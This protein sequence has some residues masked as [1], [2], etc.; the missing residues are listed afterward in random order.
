MFLLRP[1]PRSQLHVMR[2]TERSCHGSESDGATTG[3]S[4]TA[5]SATA[6]T[7]IASVTAR[8]VTT[9]GVPSSTPLVTPSAAGSSTRNGVS[10]AAPP[11]PPPVVVATQNESALLSTTTGA[12]S[13]K[14]FPVANATITTTIISAAAG[15]GGRVHA[16]DGSEHP[17]AP[18]TTPTPSG[19]CDV[20]NKKITNNNASGNNLK[21]VARVTPDHSTAQVG[22]TDRVGSDSAGSE[23]GPAALSVERFL[24]I[25]N[26]ATAAT[27]N[28]VASDS[29]P[30]VMVLPKVCLVDLSTT[31][32]APGVIDNGFGVSA[33]T[34]ASGGF[35]L[36]SSSPPA[37]RQGSETSPWQRAIQK[38][39]GR[40]IAL[41]TIALRQSTNKARPVR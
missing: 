14:C 17:T 35:R 29:V 15:N 37:Q 38:E 7:N 28:G 33:P 4:T 6:T 40:E 11:P 8:S 10:F 36:G 9:A 20:S 26:G 39:K 27:I 16:R 22:S 3:T 30:R 2:Y 13:R 23:D 1:S 19:L 41:A 18:S 25:S 31:I 5:T 21:L 24:D 12:T 34:P 32:H